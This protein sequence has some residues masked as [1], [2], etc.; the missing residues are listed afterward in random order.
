MLNFLQE[1]GLGGRLAYP[2]PLPADAAHAAGLES[3]FARTVQE[4]SCSGPT[5]DCPLTALAFFRFFSLLG[6]SWSLSWPALGLLAFNLSILIDFWTI[7]VRI[8]MIFGI[9]NL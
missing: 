2:L 1:S 8:W 3:F 4:A 6:L 7:L 5:S 9:K